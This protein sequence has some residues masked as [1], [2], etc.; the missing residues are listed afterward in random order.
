MTNDTNEQT[1]R[2][3][4]SW[5]ARTS[6]LPELINTGLALWGWRE[7][8]ASTAMWSIAVLIVRPLAGE[9]LP[10][11]MMRRYFD[12]VVRRLGVDL[13]AEGLPKLYQGLPCIIVVNH[14]SLLDIPCVGSLFDFDY[15][16]LAK[17]EL[18][19]VPFIGWH[20]WACGH[21]PVD[22]GGHSGGMRRLTET[23]T[24]QL[25]SG[26]SVLVFP[27]GTRSPDGHLQRFRKGAFVMAVEAGVPVVPI[28]MNG[29]EKLLDRG[30]IAF[31]RGPAKTVQVK[32]CEPVMP[33]SEGSR[34]DRVVR[35]RDEVRRAMVTA[36][37]ELRGQPGAAELPTA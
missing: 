1:G 20:L 14:N 37:D 28:V 18:F 29:T 11:Q 31:P 35:L 12:G 21:I 5:K 25:Q 9:R 16:W 30:S 15:K 32:V 10:Q 23:V 24:R 13:V 34:D 36:L 22:R 8:L 3:D 7:I 2:K 17:R 19:R 27:E 33:S 26:A 6:S 4:V